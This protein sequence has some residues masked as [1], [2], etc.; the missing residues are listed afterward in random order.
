QTCHMLGAWIG[1]IVPYI[2]LWPSVLEKIT[3]DLEQWKAS[4]PTLEGKH[5]IINMVIGG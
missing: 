4:A 1:N 2:T 5:H 3:N